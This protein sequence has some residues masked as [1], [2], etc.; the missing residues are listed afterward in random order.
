[1]TCTIFTLS[2]LV[3]ESWHVPSAPP[4]VNREHRLS[5]ANLYLNSLFPLAISS[6]LP[7]CFGSCCGSHINHYQQQQRP[8]PP[9]RSPTHAFT[10]PIHAPNLAH[11]TPY[12]PT[13]IKNSWQSLSVHE[14]ALSEMRIVGL[15]RAVA[16]VSPAFRH[17][18]A[19]LRLYVTPRPS[20]PS[21]NNQTM[22]RECEHS[23]VRL[24]LNSFI[25]TSPSL[26]FINS[27]RHSHETFTRSCGFV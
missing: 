25:Y 26:F 23:C 16:R 21:S 14:G 19:C 8:P 9:T 17:A 27:L 4:I 10:H 6:R 7:L 1:L 24:Y 2:L 5:T 15:Q 3:V 13:A 18:E 20:I 11:L 12:L 22:A